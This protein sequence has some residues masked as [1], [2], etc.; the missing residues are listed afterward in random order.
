MNA[1]DLHPQIRKTIA[2]APRL[3]FASPFLRPLAKMLYNVGAGSNLREGVNVTSRSHDGLNMRVYEP[4]DGGSDAAILWFYGGGHLAG[5]PEH[6][7]GIASLAVLELGVTVFVPKYRLAPK[8][9]FPADLDDAYRAWAWLVENTKMNDIDPAKLA[10]AG[11]SAGGGIAAALAQRVYDAGGVQPLAQLLFYPMLDDS[12]AA[13]RSYD[14]DNHWIWNNKAN[15]AAWSAYLKPH[16]PGADTLPE[17]AA[18]ERRSDL[19]GLPPTWVG[20][21]GLDLFFDEYSR[22]ADRLIGAGVHC[23]THL[24]DSVPHAFEVFEPDAAISREF[25]LSALDFLRQLI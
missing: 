23:E 14:A 9:P 19:S 3:P 18:P 5:K 15:L 2:K 11:H 12:V 22:Y 6:L 1:N 7:D 21:C 13:D 8:H 10:I 25:E 17:Y 20:Q 4:L 24:V 16:L